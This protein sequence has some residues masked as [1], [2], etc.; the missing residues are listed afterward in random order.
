MRED[1]EQSLGIIPAPRK[2]GIALPE[3]VKRHNQAR[4]DNLES[5]YAPNVASATK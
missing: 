4:V 2:R 5:C 3:S 1:K